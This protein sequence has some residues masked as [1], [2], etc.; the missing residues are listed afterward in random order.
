MVMLID[1]DAPTGRRTASGW[2]MMAS[3]RAAVICSGATLT[4]Y[5]VRKVHGPP[6]TGRLSAWL[7]R[8]N[9]LAPL[10]CLA[11]P[12]DWKRAI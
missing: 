10:V 12:A 7:W 5:A 4:G 9:V 6:C 2:L 8:G 1:A 11:T 3:K